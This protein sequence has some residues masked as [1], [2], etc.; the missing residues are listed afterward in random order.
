[1]QVD[2]VKPTLKAPGTKRLKLK[3]DEPLSDF[4]FNFNMRRC[5]EACIK[6]CEDAIEKGRELRV[7]YKMIGRAMTRKVRSSRAR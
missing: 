5:N 3:C 1:M 4:A 6:N 2:P 7:E